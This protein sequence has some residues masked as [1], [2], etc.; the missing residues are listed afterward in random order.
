MNGHVSHAKYRHSLLYV[1]LL[2][3]RSRFLGAKKKKKNIESY[4]Y[5]RNN[6]RLETCDG[7][8]DYHVLISRAFF[9]YKPKVPSGT[10][11][12]LY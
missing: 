4:D 9:L 2:R 3:S 10:Y 5:E 6:F 8:L 12:G 11:V 7:T 1:L